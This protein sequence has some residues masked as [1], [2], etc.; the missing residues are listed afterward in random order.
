MKKTETWQEIRDGTPCSLPLHPPLRS[1][2]RQRSPVTLVNVV[3]QFDVEHCPRYQPIRG[4]TW[5][6]IFLWD[7]TS[8]LDCEIPH[9]INEDRKICAPGSGRELSANGTISWLENVGAKH[10]WTPATTEQARHVAGL[11]CPVV[12]CWANAGGHGHVAIVLPSDEAPADLRI[13]QAGRV[14]FCG[15][16]LSRGFGSHVSDVGFWVH[17]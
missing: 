15:D 11:G 13:A 16:T 12:A 4:V 5:C 6:N 7:V 2:I 1:L 14:C 8:A 10:G 17:Q 3:E 9:W